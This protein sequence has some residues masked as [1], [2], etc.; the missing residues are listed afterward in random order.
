M[1]IVAEQCIKIFRIV[2]GIRS[3]SAQVLE[4]W[5]GRHFEESGIRF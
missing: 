4:S 1:L 3:C 2:K 5:E